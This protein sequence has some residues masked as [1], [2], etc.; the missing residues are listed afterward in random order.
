[1]SEEK[2]SP[3]DFGGAGI[4]LLNDANLT[5]EEPL[6]FAEGAPRRVAEASMRIPFTN[7]YPDETDRREV[8]LALSKLMEEFV[9]K[10]E[11]QASALFPSATVYE[12]EVAKT[13]KCLEEYA[14]ACC[15]GLPK[16]RSYLSDVEP[17]ADDHLHLGSNF[18]MFTLG[19]AALESVEGFYDLVFYV[20][21]AHWTAQ[22]GNS[23]SA[24]MVSI[25]EASWN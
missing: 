12:E 19:C 2:N 8:V 16:Y 25:I 24:E 9:M 11:M 23:G 10:M 20:T 13:L 5:K 15:L 1:M 21:T 7:I 6:P 4:V 14:K 3:F 17:D 18:V 22:P